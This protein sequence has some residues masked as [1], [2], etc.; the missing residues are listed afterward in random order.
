MPVTMRAGMP[1]ARASAVNRIAYAAHFFLVAGGIPH[2][3]R[4]Q[5]ANGWRIR[6]HPKIRFAIGIG[7]WWLS[8]GMRDAD[9]DLPVAARK[10]PHPMVIGIGERLGQFAG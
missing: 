8:T 6:L 5:L 2:G 9:V 7:R 10:A 3:Y 4:G 1:W